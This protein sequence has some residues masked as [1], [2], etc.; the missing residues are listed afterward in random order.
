MYS[1]AGRQLLDCVKGMDMRLRA[2]NSIRMFVWAAALLTTFTTTIAAETSSK[3][4]FIFIMADDFGWADVGF[5]GGNVA[6][7]NLDRMK[8]EGVELTQHYVYPVCSPT[9]SS[10]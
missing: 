8:A 4:N 7:P 6:T 2:L 9:R 5:H 10:L 1:S 3:P